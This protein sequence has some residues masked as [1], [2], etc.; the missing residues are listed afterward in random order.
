MSDQQQRAEGPKERPLD[1]DIFLRRRGNN[2]HMALPISHIRG[3]VTVM[4]DDQHQERTAGLGSALGRLAEARERRG[5]VGVVDPFE[6]TAG[7]QLAT[8]ELPRVA[9]RRGLFRFSQRA[10]DAVTPVAFEALDL[11]FDGDLI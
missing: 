1:G 7:D 10:R 2:P 3:I 5:P 9:Q 4:D 11:D 8:S 6:L